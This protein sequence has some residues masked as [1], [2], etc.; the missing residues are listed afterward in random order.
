MSARDCQSIFQDNTGAMYSTVV[1][2]TEGVVRGHQH[3]Y[4]ID[5]YSRDC[6]QCLGIPFLL[7]TSRV[8]YATIFHTDAVCKARYRCPRSSHDLRKRTADDTG[9]EYEAE[10]LREDICGGWG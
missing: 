7:S 2:S 1:L 9:E 4:C 10:A 5:E 6:S 8:L 3:R